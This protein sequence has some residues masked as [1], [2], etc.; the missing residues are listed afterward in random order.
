MN[1]NEYGYLELNIEK[2]LKERNISKNTLCKRM[3]IPR[4][5]LN[6]YCRN[7]FERIDANLLCKLLCFFQCSVDEL[8]TYK[9]NNT[10]N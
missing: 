10:E 4:S 5:N 1:K 9:P 8:I 6:R 2:L 3:D 7:D